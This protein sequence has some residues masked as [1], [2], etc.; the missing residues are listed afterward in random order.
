MSSLL[1]EFSPR[2]A[3]GPFAR[4]I[5]WKSAA[6]A[7]V[8]DIRFNPPRPLPAS[9]SFRSFLLVP[10][11]LSGLYRSSAFSSACLSA[12]APRAFPFLPCTQF[13]LFELERDESPTYLYIAH[14][15]NRLVGA[16]SVVDIKNW[17]HG[18]FDFTTTKR[19]FEKFTNFFGIQKLKNSGFWNSE[20]SCSSWKSSVFKALV[21]LFR[22]LELDNLIILLSVILFVI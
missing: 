8:A 1:D 13:V 12:Y 9:P 18:N 11:G 2:N 21:N 5:V 15:L 22:S 3:I 16:S 6:V 10:R 17:L 7:I 4:R 14:A 20:F 19:I